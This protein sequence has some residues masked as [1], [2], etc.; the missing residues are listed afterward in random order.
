MIFQFNKMR[1][2]LACSQGAVAVVSAIVF[3]VLLGF[4][5]LGI[6]VGHWY[7]VQ[8]TMQASTDAAAM[9]AAA[10]YI[11]DLPTNPNL[12]TTKRLA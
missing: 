5:S 4:T 9:S 10:Q 3:P 1:R 11:A 8:R 12:T 2:F 6:E 7:L